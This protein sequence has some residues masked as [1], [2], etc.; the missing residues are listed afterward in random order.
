L[1]GTITGLTSSGLV[2]Q[3]NSGDNITI[4]SGSTTFSFPTSVANGA[5]YSVTVL[6]QPT[7]PV[8]TCSVNN[9]TGTVGATVS[10]ISIVCN[11]VSGFVYF[12]DQNIANGIS[13]YRI[14]SATGTLSFIGTYATGASPTG[15]TTDHIGHF[16]YVSHCNGGAGTCDVSSYSIGNDGSLTLNGTIS[17]GW[18]AQSISVNPTGKFAYIPNNSS[19]VTGYNINSATGA[20]NSVG[21][22]TTGTTPQFVA[23]DPTS[24]YAYVSN[25]TTGNMSA[26]SINST[27]GAL[28]NLGTYSAGTNPDYVV[29]HPTGNFVYGVDSSGISEFSVN[30]GGTLVS[31]GSV[32]VG[33]SLSMS[34]EPTGNFAFLPIYTGSIVTY[35]INSS[36]GLLTQVNTIATPAG[37]RSISID[38]SGNFVYVSSGASVSGYSINLISGAL[39]PITSTFPSGGNMIMFALSPNH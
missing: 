3:N 1:S 24:R 22:Y 8:Q 14:N 7:A 32:S 9:G 17:T 33:N 16:L 5:A 13:G 28:V 34:I 15:I 18:Y 12:V 30:V 38:P 37:A 10:N 36:T 26:F 39:T 31:T 23:I 4:T 20:L 29:V 25:Y 21:I 35:Q 2:L 11:A 19:S 6:T 27:T